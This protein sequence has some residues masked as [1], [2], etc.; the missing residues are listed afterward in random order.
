MRVVAALAAAFVVTAAPYSARA[1]VSSWFFLGTGP[2]WLRHAGD[3]EQA[4]TVQLDTGLGSSP[5]DPIIVGGLGR[6]AAHVG[7]GAD[8]GLLARIATRGFVL[9][10]WGAAVDL[11]AYRRWWT[12]RSTGGQG[13]LVLGAPWGLTL[14]LNGGMGSRDSSHWGAT[15]G[16]DFARLTVYRTSGVDWWSNP[17]PPGPKS[18]EQ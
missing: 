9:G 10:G 6:L 15:L 5:A 12:P 17:F 3:T 7:H 13:S 14:G 1:D 16:V 8:L 11:G 2:T 18:G 4:W